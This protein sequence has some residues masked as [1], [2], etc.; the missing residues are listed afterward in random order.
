M[1]SVCSS[2]TEYCFVLL[3]LSILLPNTYPRSKCDMEVETIL[4]IVLNII[5]SASE[6]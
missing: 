5:I 4:F 1:C 3:Y 6:L 2:V